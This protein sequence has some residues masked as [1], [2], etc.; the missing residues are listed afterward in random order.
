MNKKVARICAIILG[1][2][3]ILSTGCKKKDDS[4][5]KR[6]VAEDDP[7][8]TSETVEISVPVNP[9]LELDYGGGLFEVRFTAD[10]VAGYYNNG[11]KA[12]Q[13]V[14]DQINELADE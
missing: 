4:G 3:V 6:I 10:R 7:Y 14:Q 2:S 8:F 12:P 11:Y 5:K 13:E 1:L 9:D